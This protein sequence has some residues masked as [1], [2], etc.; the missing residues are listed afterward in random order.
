PELGGYFNLAVTRGL[1]LT[2]SLRFGAGE[3]RD[4]AQLDLGAV[5][6]M[7]LSPTVR[8]S[9]SAGLTWV[10]SALSQ[11]YFGVSP[12]QSVASG[13]APYSAGSG[14]RDARLS[15][16]VVWGVAPRW[17]MTTALSAG[18]LLGDARHSPITRQVNSVSA[19]L[20]TSYS[21]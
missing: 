16:A 9:V 11:T 1:V 14:L 17:N 12:E 18:R 19:V 6:G 20:G 3:D 8:F 5:S 7:P 2:S 4:G 13:L 21:F 10:N 15:T